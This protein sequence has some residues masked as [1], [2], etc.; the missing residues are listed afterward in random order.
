MTGVTGI[1]NGGHSVVVDSYKEEQKHFD[2]REIDGDIVT[3]DFSPA[4]LYID[5][6]THL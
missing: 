1:P 4:I 3:D 6:S 5:E 2:D